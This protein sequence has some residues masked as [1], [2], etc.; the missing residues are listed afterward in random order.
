MYHFPEGAIDDGTIK[1]QRSLQIFSKDVDGAS[2][3][4]VLV[5]DVIDTPID[6][7]ASERLRAARLGCRGFR[8]DTRAPVDVG[9][10]TGEAFGWEYLDDD[11]G[12]VAAHQIL[13]AVGDRVI[14][15]SATFPVAMR[16]RC[17]RVL[18]DLANAMRWRVA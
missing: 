16:E 9:G 11:V 15:L 14:S 13:A 8:N 5:A 12:C 6:E 3:S 7:I 2:L 4:I 1:A 10:A 17:T 18:I